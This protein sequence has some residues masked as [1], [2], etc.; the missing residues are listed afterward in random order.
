ML[1]RGTEK[2]EVTQKNASK[3]WAAENKEMFS[4]PWGIKEKDKDYILLRFARCDTNKLSERNSFILR[5][6]SSYF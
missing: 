1:K 5:T 6:F 3:C 4:N 2:T